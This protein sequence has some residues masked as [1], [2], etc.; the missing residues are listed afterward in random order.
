MNDVLR[1][2]NIKLKLADLV[3]GQGGEGVK[4]VLSQHEKELLMER[5]CKILHSPREEI[6]DVTVE[7][8]SIDARK[9]DD[10]FLVYTVLVEG[11]SEAKWKRMKNVTYIPPMGRGEEAKPSERLTARATNPPS[12]ASPPSG[13]NRPVVVGMGPAGLFCAYELARRGW[14]PILLD[15]GADVDARVEKVNRFWATGD[16]D[17]DTNVQFGEGGAGT[18]SDGKLNTMVKDPSGRN[19]KVLNLFVEHGAPLE[20]AYLAKPHVG[21]ERLRDVV[22]SIRKRIV[23]WGGEVRFGTKL[24][25]VDVEGGAV[26][27]CTIKTASAPV[28]EWL[29]CDDLVLAIGHSARDTFAMLYD[30]GVAMTSKPF[31][32]GVRVEHEQDMVNAVQYGD[33]KDKLPPADYK[34]THQTSGGRGVYTFCMC[35]GGYVVNASSEKDGLAINGMSN[36]NRE[37]RNAN[38]AIVVTVTPEDYGRAM[39]GGPAAL[40]GMEF[41]RK[42]EGMAYQLA[43]GRIPVQTYGDFERHREP[44]ELGKLTPDCKGDYALANVRACLPPYV[45]DAIVEGV[46][47][48]G[49]R[50][51]GFADACTIISGVETRTSSPVRIPRDE[52][53]QSNVGGLYPCGEGAGYAGGIMS[54]AMDGLKVAEACLTRLEGKA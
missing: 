44:V 17:A 16:L 15:R 54:A 27:G 21:T 9:K 11:L 50:M 53:M 52:A 13:S 43:G 12:A 3:D 1:I 31:A 22:K 48:F 34:L 47:A 7:R 29:P 49:G 38:S 41:Q 19:R 45:G 23:E 25:G 8:K 26:R 37:G 30:Y 32:I 10:V 14:R 35:P 39:L 40:M 51:R 6:K 33:W 42:Y 24:V 36:Y 20:I 5:I 4:G 46:R 18:F 2:T 28:S